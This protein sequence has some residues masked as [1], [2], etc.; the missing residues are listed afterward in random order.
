VTNMEIKTKLNMFITVMAYRS[1]Y[2]S[3][4]SSCYSIVSITE[5]TEWQ[6]PLSVVHSIMMVK[7]AQPGKGGECTSSPLNSI[8]HH[9]QS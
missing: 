9:K 3:D 5:Y 4:I 6:W 7:S 1:T 2:I 8:Y